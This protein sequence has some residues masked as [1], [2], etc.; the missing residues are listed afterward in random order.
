V[1]QVW[2]RQKPRRGKLH[3]NCVFASSWICGSLSAF[4]CFRDEKCQ[5]AFFMLG[6]DQIG[7]EKKRAR[8]RYAEH[9]FLHPVEFM[10]HVVHSC[11][12]EARNVNA[13]FFM[14][15]WHRYRFDNKCARIHYTKLVFLHPVGSVGHLV[16]SGAS[17]ARNIH[18][19]FFLLWCA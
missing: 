17:M 15:G 10:G 11:M 6:W 7:F 18:A 2:I 14:L 4:R 13:L 12:S 19:L 1:G 3:Q 8:T 9:V 5:H 16:H